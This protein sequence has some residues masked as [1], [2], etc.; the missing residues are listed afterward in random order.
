MSIQMQITLLSLANFDYE[1]NIYTHIH[2][3]PE[4]ETEH[5]LPLS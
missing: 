3:V 2:I 5:T 4:F 1:V